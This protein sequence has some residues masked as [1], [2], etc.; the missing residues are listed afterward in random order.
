MSIKL[1]NYLRQLWNIVTVHVMCRLYLISHTLERILFD[2]D[3][4]ED[5]F[6]LH[7]NWRSIPSCLV[8]RSG[9]K[10]GYMTRPFVLPIRSYHCEIATR[11]PR[12]VADSCIISKAETNYRNIYCSRFLKISFI[13]GTAK[14]SENNRRL[15]RYFVWHESSISICLINYWCFPIS[16]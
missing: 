8:L 16:E 4:C 2:K 10:C 11:L 6:W 1:S 9:A 15:W 12:R 13:P 3:S 14:I 5:A 7:H